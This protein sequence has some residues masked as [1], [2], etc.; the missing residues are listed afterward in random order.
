V[1]A[2]EEPGAGE[3]DEVAIARVGLG[4]QREVVAL[5]ARRGVAAVVDEIDLAALDR[6]DP[7]LLAGLEQLDGAIHHPVVG[8]AQGGLPEGRGALGE[9]VDRAGSVEQGVL[10]VDMEM[11]AGGGGHGRENLAAGSDG[12]RGVPAPS[13]KPPCEPG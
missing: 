6:L 11:G 13:G 8:K 1:Q 7:V 4:Q 5:L 12:A 10:R 9:R 3:L 2:L